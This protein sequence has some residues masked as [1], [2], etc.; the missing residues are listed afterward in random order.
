MLENAIEGH[1]AKACMQR[2][3]KRRH[4]WRGINMMTKMTLTIGNNLLKEAHGK[5][6]DVDT[7]HGKLVLIQDCQN[8]INDVNKSQNLDV[9]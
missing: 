1:V 8:D 6:L 2:V 4:N 9:F 3:T 5:L 7:F